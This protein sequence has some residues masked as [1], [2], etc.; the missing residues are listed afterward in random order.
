MEQNHSSMY[1]VKHLREFISERLTAA[2]EEIFG[3]FE[4]TIEQQM[5]HQ[6]RLLDSS[7]QETD[8]QQC[9]LT[10]M[11]SLGDQQIS[12]QMENFSEDQLEAVP[13]EIKEEQE[14]LW[15]DEGDAQMVLKQEADVQMVTPMFEEGDQSESK[16]HG[17]QFHPKR[18][19]Q[20]VSWPEDFEAARNTEQKERWSGK[21]MDSCLLAKGDGSS[22]LQSGGKTTKT[23]GTTLYTIHTDFPNHFL[24]KEAKILEEQEGHAGRDEEEPEP[25]EIKEEQDPCFRTDT[26][27]LAVKQEINSFM[28]T[29]DYE[30]T[31]HNESGPNRNQPCSNSS[32]ATESKY[33]EGTLSEESGSSRNW[34]NE[35]NIADNLT[36]LDSLCSS[37][38][39]NKS[40]KCGVCG[41]TFSSNFKMRKHYRIHTGEKPY[42]CKICRKAFRESK[43]LSVHMRT[44]TGEKPYSCETCGKSFSQNSHLSSH[45]RTHTG[46]KPHPCSTCGR[47]FAEASALRNHMLTHT[48]EKP[49]SCHICGKILRYSSSLSAH[50]KIHTGEKPFACKTCGKCFSHNSSLIS[51]MRIHTGEKSYQCTTCGR[52]FSHSTTLLR[53]TRSHTGE[54]PYSCATCGKCFNSSSH[55]TVHMTTHTREK[56]YSCTMCSKRFSHGSNLV[57]HMRTHTG[58]RPYS[59]QTCAKRFKSSTHLSRHMKTHRK[60][61]NPEVEIILEDGSTPV[62]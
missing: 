31:E 26:D 54:R 3:V 2:A 17:D 45:K 9:F 19:D 49:F 36:G 16:S 28:V 6:R 33:L 62:S 40:L 50:M 5:D 27:Q 61:C 23:S 4:R 20:E 47:R 24:W 32:T 42:S 43:Y 55:L 7:F 14:E 60:G 59:C 30:E 35:N 12:K 37:D 22:S 41:K 34:K 21:Q 18:P 57:R 29:S 56:L 58:E 10:K 38:L 15:A 13:P 46:E 48:G 1:S 8:V 53:H 52:C 39:S 25:L 51:H 44:H 11:E